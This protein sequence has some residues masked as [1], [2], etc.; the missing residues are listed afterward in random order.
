LYFAKQTPN[1]KIFALVKRVV[2][3]TCKFCICTIIVF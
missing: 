2:N 3:I 1:P